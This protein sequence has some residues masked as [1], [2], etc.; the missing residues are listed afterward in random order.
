MPASIP[1]KF[2]IFTFA[3]KAKQEM[4]PEKRLRNSIFS[5]ITRRNN[6]KDKIN[7]TVA[8]HFKQPGHIIRNVICVLLASLFKCLQES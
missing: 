7:F 5:L 3:I 1:L 4:I 2:Y 8:A 6:I